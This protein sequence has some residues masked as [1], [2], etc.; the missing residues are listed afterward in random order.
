MATDKIDVHAHYIPEVYREALVAA[1]QDRP[2]G[3]RR[4]RGRL[5]I[6]A[7]LASR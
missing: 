5:D 4:G 6:N 2:D 7:C 3:T 1:A